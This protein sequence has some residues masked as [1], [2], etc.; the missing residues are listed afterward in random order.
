MRP[1]LR[2]VFLLSSLSVLQ[3]CAIIGGIFKAGVAV[4]I[5]MA[6]IVV[7]VVVILIVR[8]TRM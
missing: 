2:A 5:F 8:G 3:G 1:L 4:G 6:V 7:I